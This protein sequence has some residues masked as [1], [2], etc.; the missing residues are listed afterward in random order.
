M[1]IK[2]WASCPT[3]SKL[4]RELAELDL[5]E[6][7]AELDVFGFTIVP[8]EKVGPPEFHAALKQAVIDVVSKRFGAPGNDGLS[9]KDKN[10]II[11]MILWENPVFEELLLNPA[12][13][14]LIQHLVGSNCILSLFDGWVKGPGEGRTPIHRDNWDFTRHASPPEPN[15]ANFNYLVT[16]YSAAD[17][18]ITFVP[19]SHKWR[20]P[21]SPAEMEQ[22]ADKAEPIEA[23]AGSMVVWGDLTWH[24]SALRSNIGER[25][26][27][28]GTYS[29]PFMQ[30]QG[31]YR[32]TVTAEALARNPLRFAGLM[33]VYGAFPFG[34]QDVDGDRMR[35]G[36]KVSSGALDMSPYHSLFDREPAGSKVS[37]RPD[38]DY[39]AF[40]MDAH[41]E[42]MKVRM[43][44]R[45][46][47]PKKPAAKTK[48]AKA[49]ATTRVKAASKVK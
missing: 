45:G 22:W 39:F 43:A 20:R 7:I 14:G 49:K 5:L 2:D 13:L 6:N 35:E 10:Q 11:R 37:V 28:L 12:G 29:R 33:D 9:W 48:A 27:I 32:Q 31:P 40:D 4:Y 44:M 24:G 36:A 23:P 18:A 15:S 16:D 42:N 25:L 30:T 1:Q 46:G 34:E 21:P 47:A 8:P 38:Y 17:G 19:G 3:Q 41:R 26:M